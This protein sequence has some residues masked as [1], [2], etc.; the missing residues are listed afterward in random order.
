MSTWI[1]PHRWRNMSVF[2]HLRWE[3]GQAL[4]KP[5]L[6][7]WKS[8]S[9]NMLS[10]KKASSRKNTWDTWA[11]DEAPSGLEGGSSCSR[12]RVRP[13]RVSRNN[14]SGLSCSAWPLCERPATTKMRG[15]ASKINF[16][17][18]CWC[19]YVKKNTWNLIFLIQWDQQIALNCWYKRFTRHC[20]GFTSG[21]DACLGKTWQT[22]C[23]RISPGTVHHALAGNK[24]EISLCFDKH[25]YRFQFSVY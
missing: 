1:I 23:Y 9:L 2:S 5:P 18:K 10:L 20:S 3:S 15:V 7:W 25:V 24:V 16:A 6:R 17:G 22:A 12:V 8:L 21:P 13:P 19:I 4:A 11:N 14:A